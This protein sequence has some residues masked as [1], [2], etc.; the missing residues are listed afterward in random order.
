ME[1]TYINQPDFDRERD[2]AVS[3][4]L[5]RWDEP[6]PPMGHYT[7]GLTFGKPI[8]KDS[9]LASGLYKKSTG[10]L[11]SLTRCSMVWQKKL[12]R[13]VNYNSGRAYGKG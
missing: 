1:F 13:Y 2:G 11:T 5:D 4:I 8:T 9:R 12:I 3:K 10:T 6:L 7:N